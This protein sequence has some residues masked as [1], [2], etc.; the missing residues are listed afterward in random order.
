MSDDTIPF[1]SMIAALITAGATV[2]LVVGAFLAWHI[3]RTTLKQMRDDSARQTRPYVYAVLVPGLWGAGT[4]D[5]DLRNTGQSAARR[6][7][8]DFTGWPSK[9]DLITDGL[10]SLFGEEQTLPPGVSVRTMWRTT[11]DPG[12][13][14][15]GPLS[16]AVNG[17]PN[18]ATITF[19]YCGEDPNEPEYQDTY[20]LDPDIIAPITPMASQ[21]PEPS[22]KLTEGERSRHRMLQRVVA[23]LGELRR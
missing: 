7:T 5:L 11:T 21:G 14:A 6:L 1:W 16:D 20:T 19:K 22:S 9:D 13:T 23:G 17:I 3:A 18:A 8:A 15:V 4:W 10:R 12:G 2:G